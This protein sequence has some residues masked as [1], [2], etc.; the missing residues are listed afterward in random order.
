MG[1]GAA[2]F[3]RLAISVCSAAGISGLVMGMEQPSALPPQVTGVDASCWSELYVVYM[4]R[5]Y[6]SATSGTM[7]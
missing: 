2:G 3:G 4:M 1:R 5:A 7:S 6:I